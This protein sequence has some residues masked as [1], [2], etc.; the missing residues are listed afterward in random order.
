MKQIF[1]QCREDGSISS[2][3]RY[4][5]FASE[6]LLVTD[7][8]E[9]GGSTVQLYP[10]DNTTVGNYYMQYLLANGTAIT[11][12]RENN[13]QIASAGTG[14]KAFTIT[15]IKITNAGN[16]VYQSDI[17]EAYGESGLVLFK[18]YSTSTFTVSS[19]TKLSIK[20]F[21]ANAIGIGSRFTL[22]KL[23]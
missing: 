13:N 14:K 15:K 7:F 3:V 5:N 18:K 16:V 11:A 21:N 19:I 23:R 12:T 22:Y 9:N 10:N 4:L 2:N 1:I 8:V 17:V 6:N 20:S